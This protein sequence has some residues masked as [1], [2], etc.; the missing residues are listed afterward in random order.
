MATHDP[1][2]RMTQ[3][4][5]LFEGRG[6]RLTVREAQIEG[7]VYPLGKITN[8]RT[9]YRSPSLVGPVLFGAAGILSLC[10]AALTAV[11]TLALREQGVELG[12]SVELVLA[13]IGG[14]VVFLLAAA[15]CGMRLRGWHVIVLDTESGKH[16]AL[17]TSDADFA[18]T[19]RAALE[20]ALVVYSESLPTALIEPL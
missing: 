5:V 13:E 2:A 3:D 14:A 19:V 4:E 9:L 15:I 8:V 17:A 12:L 1:E 16:R 10:F 7:T 18:A 20:E 11:L 6:V